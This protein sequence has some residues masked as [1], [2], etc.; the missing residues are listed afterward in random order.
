MTLLLATTNQGKVREIRRA[1]V[2]VAVEL[3]TLDDILPCREPE[4]TGHTFAENAEQKARYYALRLR[5][6][7]TLRQGSE[8]LSHGTW[9]TVAEDSGLVIDALDGAP[10]VLSA[11]YPGS[12]YPEKFANL[13]RALAPHPRPWVARFVCAL[14]VVGPPDAFAPPPNGDRFASGADR[15]LFTCEAAVEGEI[16]GS[17]RGSM[18][19]GYDPIFLFP[20][21]GRTFGEVGDEEKLAVSHRGQAFQMLRNWLAERA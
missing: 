5:S 12:T 1:L 14:A 8:P 19:F 2:D 16:V 13:Y 6:G 20:P 18:G 9:P 7:Q 17:P 21:Y 4:E 15:V 11:R 10:G 3:R